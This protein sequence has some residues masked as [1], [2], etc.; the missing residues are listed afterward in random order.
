MLLAACV[1]AT[2]TARIEREP[3]VFQSLPPQHQQLVREGRICNGMSKDGVRLA[4]GR[5]DAVY[6]GS[7]KGRNA[8]RWD[9]F[10][11]RPVFVDGFT[12]GQ[13]WSPMPGWGYHVPG[14]VAYVPYRAAT[15]WFV[16]GKVEEWERLR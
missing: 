5:P 9:F 1:P 16:G 4:W 3:S 13:P 2:P 6:E 10:H 15:V 8:D 14:E 12:Y 11:L 7:R